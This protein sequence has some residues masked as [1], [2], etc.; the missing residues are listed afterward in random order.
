MSLLDVYQR[1]LKFNSRSVLRIRKLGVSTSILNIKK[2]MLRIKKHEWYIGREWR[3][4]SIGLDWFTGGFTAVNVLW[5]VTGLLILIAIVLKI[6]NRD[7]KKGEIEDSQ[8]SPLK[9]IHNSVLLERYKYYCSRENRRDTC[10]QRSQRHK[11]FIPS[12]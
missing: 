5:T 7:S 1:M 10:S 4:Y 12:L 11:L 9:L 8:S 3:T 6:K 2:L